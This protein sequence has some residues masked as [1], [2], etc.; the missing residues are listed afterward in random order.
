MLNPLLRENEH[1][2]QQWRGVNQTEAR[3]GTVR[4]SKLLELFGP[5]DEEE[6]QEITSG[7]GILSKFLDLMFCYHTQLTG[8]KYEAELE[9]AWDFS[10]PLPKVERVR[11]SGGGSDPQQQMMRLK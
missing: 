9:R 7:L 8:R 2:F 4:D 1:H 5:I 10:M 6:L 11:L 3:R